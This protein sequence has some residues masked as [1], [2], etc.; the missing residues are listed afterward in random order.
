MPEASDQFDAVA[1]ART[2]ALGRRGSDRLTDEL[3]QAA[4]REGHAR[5]ESF[6]GTAYVRFADDYHGVPR[7]VVVMQGRVIP[8]YPP[9]GRIF[10]L[11][12]GLRRH[13]AGR[14]HAEEK[15]DGYNVRIAC[16]GGRLLPFTRGGFVCPFTADR[17]SD[18]GRFAAL[19]DSWSSVASGAARRRLDRIDSWNR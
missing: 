4:L 14:F 16:V 3:L 9:I 11:E 6:D 13:F 15:L 5:E 2:G 7:G 18:L 8:S 1:A 12:N 17:L 10:A 19:F